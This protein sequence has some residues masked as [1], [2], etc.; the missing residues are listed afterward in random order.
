M[1]QPASQRAGVP[2]VT[3]SL[4]NTIVQLGVSPSVPDIPVAKAL[5]A[6]S[7]STPAKRQCRFL[8]NE[9]IPDSPPYSRFMTAALPSLAQAVECDYPETAL[10][11]VLYFDVDELLRIDCQ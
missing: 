3:S 4:A 5:S 9:I 7:T 8:H 10:E 6:T 11:I 2:G 1:A